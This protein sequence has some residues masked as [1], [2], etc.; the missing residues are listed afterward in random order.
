MSTNRIMINKL[1]RLVYTN[2][3]HK[4]GT[5]TVAYSSKRAVLSNK[6]DLLI[7]ATAWMNPQSMMLSDI[8]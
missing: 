1:D 6:R 7:H 8:I 5:L 2:R 3:I 4:L